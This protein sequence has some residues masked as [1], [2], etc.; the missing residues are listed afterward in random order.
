MIIP[1]NCT[2]RPLHLQC[3]CTTTDSLETI[4]AGFK[5]LNTHKPMK[6]CGIRSRNSKILIYAQRMS[7]LFFSY[8]NCGLD[9]PTC[10][11]LCHGLALLSLVQPSFRAVTAAAD[12]QYSAY[13]AGSW[14]NKS[15]REYHFTC[16]CHHCLLHHSCTKNRPL[17]L[18]EQYYQYTAYLTPQTAQ[19]PVLVYLS[20]KEVDGQLNISR[21]F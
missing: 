14:R 8:T 20:L 7:L 4:N 19:P 10:A 2:T 9:A 3:T 12:T 6:Q 16:H 11:N 17:S 13:R 15:I 1:C 18:T 5:L 21:H